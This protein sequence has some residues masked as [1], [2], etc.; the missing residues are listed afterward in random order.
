[1]ATPKARLVIRAARLSPTPKT[2]RFQAFFR[3][4]VMN[5]LNAY[6]RLPRK[7]AVPPGPIHLASN[8]KPATRRRSPARYTA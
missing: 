8:R 3:S 1:M 5:R 2:K 6:I 4:T 7:A